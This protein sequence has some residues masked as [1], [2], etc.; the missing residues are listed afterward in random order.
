MATPQA[1]LL[2]HDRTYT[3][4]QKSFLVF[5]KNSCRNHQG[6]DTLQY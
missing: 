2:Q 4:A 3:E 6:C 1:L 5:N